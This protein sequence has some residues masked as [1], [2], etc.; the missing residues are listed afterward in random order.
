MKRLIAGLCTMVLASLTL[1]CSLER[2]EPSPV[3]IVIVTGG[4]DFDQQAFVRI[5]DEM[6]GIRWRPFELKDDS[7]LFE[8]VSAWDYDVIVFYNMTQ[9]ISERRKANFLALMDRGVG[10]IALH[11]SMV[12]FQDWPEYK[13]IIG[14]R[15]Y[16][17]E[18]ED[19]DVT[20]PASTYKHDVQMPV[21]IA[22]KHHPVTA[23]IDDFQLFDETYKGYSLE[24]DNHILLTVEEPTSQY[25]VAWTRQ[26]RQSRICTIQPGHGADAYNHPAYRRLLQQAVQ[27][28]AR[29]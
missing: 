12:S 29:R 19:S 9:S 21:K 26:F 20:W 2:N 1:G 3:S 17:D 13:K 14:C 6:P 7:E 22:D 23:G 10:V 25:E 27:W 18:T 15:Y 16:L 4:H 5:F 28:T 11:H 24:P 8:D